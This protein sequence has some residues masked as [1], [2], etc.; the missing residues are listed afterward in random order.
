MALYHDQLKS[1][2]SQI[3]FSWYKY[4]SAFQVISHIEIYAEHWYSFPQDTRVSP[5]QV[6]NIT[7]ADT[8]VQLSAKASAALMVTLG[9]SDNPALALDK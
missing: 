1:F 8:Q 7:T 3:L 5:S 9:P 2:I 4:V 6:V